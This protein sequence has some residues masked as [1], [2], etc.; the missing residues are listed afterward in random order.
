MEPKL[1][2]EAEWTAR[3]AAWSVGE[4]YHL[5]I[6]ELDKLG[7]IAPEP[8]PLEAIVDAA[9]KQYR[10]YPSSMLASIKHAVRFAAR[11]GMELQRE[12]PPASTLAGLRTAVMTALRGTTAC[13]EYDDFNRQSPSV[14]QE[15]AEAFIDRLHAALTQPPHADRGWDDA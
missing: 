1:L 13:I 7:L 5:I 15:D 4:D 9:M 2:T 11:R 8:D 12:P 14:S 10:A 3:L 6:A